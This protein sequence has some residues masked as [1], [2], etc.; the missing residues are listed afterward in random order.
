MRRTENPPTV[1]FPHVEERL[2][3]EQGDSTMSYG[4]EDGPQI[5]G[6]SVTYSAYEY[7]KRIISLGV[8]EGSLGKMRI[9]DAM[10][11]IVDAMHVV[12]AGGEVK[13]EVLHRGNP[14]IVSE[15]RTRVEVATN[16]AN[17]INE[18]SGYYVTL[19]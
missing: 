4:A 2:G 13:I 17:V 16:D 7:L 1:L 8:F 15:L 18:K 12:L 14:D 5:I 19:M 6:H 9:S 11:P 10:Q 3:V